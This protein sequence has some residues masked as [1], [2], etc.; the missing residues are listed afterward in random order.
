MDKSNLNQ[1]KKF[2]KRNSV[3]SLLLYPLISLHGVWLKRSQISFPE[4][5]ESV[6]EKIE[7]GS[8]I[9]RIDSFNGVFEMSFKSH[10]MKRLLQFKE[11]E[12]WLAVLTNRVV[13]NSKDVIDVGA[14]VGLFTVLCADLINKDRTVLAIEPVD[15][16]LG[17]LKANIRRNKKENNVKVYEGVASDK[18]GHFSMNVIP[19]MEEYSSLGDL[20]HPEIGGQVSIKKTGSRRNH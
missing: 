15:S 7:G 5:Y 11:Y 16:A 10:I 9:I 6:F 2:I 12:S 18:T 17:F 4:F 14:N 13:E 3:L 8:L 19:G 1:V 20:V